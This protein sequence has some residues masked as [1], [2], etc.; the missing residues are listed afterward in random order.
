MTMDRVSFSLYIYLYTWIYACFLFSPVLARIASRRFA[1]LRIVIAIATAGLIL[2]ALD[3]LQLKSFAAKLEDMWGGRVGVFSPGNPNRTDPFVLFVHHRYF[4][5]KYKVGFSLSLSFISHY[6]FSVFF[7]FWGGV[8]WA[9][10]SALVLEPT[11][12]RFSRRDFSNL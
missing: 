9:R 11:Q 7:F 12:F 2:L 3:L 10:C 1:S 8:H 5:M 4:D 6:L